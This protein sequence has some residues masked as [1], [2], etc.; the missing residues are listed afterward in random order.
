MDR[1]AFIKSGVLG[2]VAHA[3]GAYT[4][5]PE[6]VHAKIPKTLKVTALKVIPV[7]NG[8]MTYVFVK[9]YTNQGITGV[10]E[11]GIRGRAG[12]MIAA[13]KEHERYIV[14]KNPLQIEKHW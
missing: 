2:G 11:G 3:L 1:R 5:F 14:G 7:W 8:S 12:T 9:L 6:N 10:G 4:L 13:I